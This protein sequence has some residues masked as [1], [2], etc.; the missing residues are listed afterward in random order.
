MIDFNDIDINET[1][2]N[3]GDTVKI[4][5]VVSSYYK[6]N[7]NTWRCFR[8]KLDNIYKVTDMI[9]GEDLDISASYLYKLSVIRYGTPLV[10]FGWYDISKSKYE[11]VF[12]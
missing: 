10:L 4:K 1:P 8:D 2:I 9:N 7:P 3:I 11:K 12:K 5:G 6:A